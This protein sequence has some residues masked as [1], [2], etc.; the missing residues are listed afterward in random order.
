MNETQSNFIASLI[1]SDCNVSLACKDNEVELRL[2]HEWMKDD[3][4][5]EG[6]DTA[7]QVRDDEALSAMMKLIRGNDRSAVVEYQKMQRQREDL[8][9]IKS[10]KREVM[11]VLINSQDTKSACL[12]EYCQ[13]FKGTKSAADDQF[14]N[15][16]A[17]LGLQTPH[18]RMKS[19]KSK[20]D[21]QMSEMFLRGE[22]LEPEMLKR[23]MALSLSDAE[24]SEYPSERQRATEKVLLLKTSIEEMNIRI[25]KES[26]SDETELIPKC[27]ALFF[28]A[29]VASCER[30]MHDLISDNVKAI[31]D[32]SDSK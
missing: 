24:N 19:K 7:I 12:K 13:I 29:S 32:A 22:L 17:E 8:N 16:V 23:L 1:G 15:V 31:E 9:E 3:S 18:Q 20:H 14:A 28:G 2:F 26:E 4:F 21:N 11:R 10:T 5:R 30:V 27:D 25:R 6:Y